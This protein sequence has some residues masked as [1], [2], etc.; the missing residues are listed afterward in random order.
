VEV[1]EGNNFDNVQRN[2]GGKVM[3]WKEGLDKVQK[4]AK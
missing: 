4:D 3:G 1:E 2:G